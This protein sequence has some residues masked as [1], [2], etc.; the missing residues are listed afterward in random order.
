MLDDIK[1][2]RSMRE[3]NPQAES[4]PIVLKREFASHFIKMTQVLEKAQ[5]AYMMDELFKDIGEI[6]EIDLNE[7]IRFKQEEDAAEEQRREE[8]E[9]REEQR[10]TLKSWIL[11]L[12]IGVGALL[13]FFAGLGVYLFY[14]FKSETTEVFV[15]S[16]P[17]GADLFVDGRDAGA[18]TPVTLQL[19]KDRT[20]IFGFHKGDLAAEMPFVP[21]DK[22]EENKVFVKLGKRS[23]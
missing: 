23:E 9:E 20:Y 11:P 13:L 22:P 12:C 17:P 16:L 15:S 6:E 3:F 18:K 2:F 10:R 8:A 7:R 4:L 19:V 21:G 1:K 5:A 14:P